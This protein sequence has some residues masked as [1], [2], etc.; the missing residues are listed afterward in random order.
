MNHPSIAESPYVVRLLG[1]ERLSASIRIAAEVAFA[2]ELERILGGAAGVA[3]ACIA[4]ERTE[5]DGACAIA[6]AAALRGVGLTTGA[7]SIA[8]RMP[9]MSRRVAACPG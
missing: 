5:F 2:R 6:S 3:S 8:R 1:G 9:S 7:F 4:A